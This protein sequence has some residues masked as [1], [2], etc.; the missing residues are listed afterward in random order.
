MKKAG[1][2][3]AGISS[4]RPMLGTAPLLDMVLHA[5]G[6]PHAGKDAAVGRMTWTNGAKREH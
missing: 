3:A 1:Y 2:N 5:H 6:H 4:L